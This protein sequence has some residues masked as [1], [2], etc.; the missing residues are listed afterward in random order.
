MIAAAATCPSWAD[1]VSV[2]LYDCGAQKQTHNKT[3]GDIAAVSCCENEMT[4]P[5]SR[6]EHVACHEFNHTFTTFSFQTC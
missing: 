2:V 5:R 6:R 4:K 3:H 1:L